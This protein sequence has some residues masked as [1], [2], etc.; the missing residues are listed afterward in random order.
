[1]T[2]LVEEAQLTAEEQERLR[3]HVEELRREA[4]E[5]PR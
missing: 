4:K 3:Q 2:Y 5:E 1:V